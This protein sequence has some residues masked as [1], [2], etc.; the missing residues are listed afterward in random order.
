[1]LRSGGAGGGLGGLGGLLR[2]LDEAG[3]ADQARSWVQ[4]GRNQPVSGREITRAL[5]AEE[6]DRLAARTGLAREEAAAGIAATLPQVVDAVTPG[7]EVPSE[8]DLDE[9]LAQFLRETAPPN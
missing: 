5:G 1:M 3:L 7:G 8:R 4:P 2:R 6:L 9:A